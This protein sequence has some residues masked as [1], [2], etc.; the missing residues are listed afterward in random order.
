MANSMRGKTA[1]SVNRVPDP[2]TLTLN[3]GTKPLNCKPVPLLPPDPVTLKQYAAPSS[4]AVMRT[5]A[6]SG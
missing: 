4:P 2:K 1:C 3:V 6:A 5:P